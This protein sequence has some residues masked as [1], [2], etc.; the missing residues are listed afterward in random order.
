MRSTAETDAVYRWDVWVAAYF[1]GGGGSDDRFTDFTAGL[2][3]ALGP[4]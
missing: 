4:Q 2:G 3:V 1:I